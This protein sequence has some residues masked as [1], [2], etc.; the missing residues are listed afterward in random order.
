[1]MYPATV[2]KPSQP[3]DT[4]VTGQVLDVSRRHVSLLTSE[5]II[6]GSIASRALDVVTGDRVE[7][8]KRDGKVFVTGVVPSTRT[9]SR[10]YRG[11]L[12]R[13]GANID[14]LFVITAV[15]P[16]LNPITTDRMLIAARVRNIPAVL[17]INKWDLET[18]ESG[19]FLEVYRKIGIPVVHCSAKFG[20]D[21][22]DVQ[23]LIHAPD[24][25]VVALCGVSGVGK[26]TILNR[27]VPGAAART[28]EVSERT[29]QGRQ[30]T[31][32]PRGFLYVGPDSSRRIIIDF[33]GVGFFGLS[34]LEEKEVAKAFDEFVHYGQQCRYRSCR[35][36]QEP[37]CGVRDAV[38]RGEIASWRYH[39]YLQ[40]LD[41]IEEAR[42]Y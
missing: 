24:V 29:G 35:H 33:P 5:G 17:V 34:H 2:A 7:Y 20:Q 40:I 14:R 6:S 27:L 12:K 42:E 30:T 23:D 32:Q 8:E 22:K 19:E 36:L 26:S 25:G 4:A 18:G 13:M 16:T 10:S 41:E 21:F 9:L 28:G 3:L 31:S 11:A 39:S 1:M 37:D 15:G 38:E